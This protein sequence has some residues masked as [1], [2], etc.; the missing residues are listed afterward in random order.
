MV[1]KMLRSF[2]YVL[3][4]IFVFHLECFDFDYYRDLFKSYDNGG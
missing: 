3:V 1:F 4:E 2:C